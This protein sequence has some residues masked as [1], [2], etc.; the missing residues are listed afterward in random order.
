MG[1]VGAGL[2]MQEWGVSYRGRVES[3]L[4]DKVTNKIIQ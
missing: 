4:S 2:V 1:H 3:Y